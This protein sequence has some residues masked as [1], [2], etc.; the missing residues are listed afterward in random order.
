MLSQSMRTLTSAAND[1]AAWAALFH[2]YNKTHGKGNTGY[3]AGQKIVIKINQNTA[4]D[5]HAENG[6]LRTRTASMATRT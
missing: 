6:N 1:P 5:G 4:R 2:C 3:L